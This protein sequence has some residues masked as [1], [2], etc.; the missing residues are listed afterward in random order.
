MRKKLWFILLAICTAG[1]VKAQPAGYYNTAHGKSGAELKIALYQIIKG[2]TEFSYRS[3]DEILDISD[4]DPTNPENVILV[5]TGRSDDKDNY[6]SGGN[7]INR[8]H[9]WAKSHGN[10]GTDKPAGSDVHNLKPADGSVNEDRSNLDFDNGGSQH[11]EATGCYYDGDSWEPRDAVKGDIARIIFYMAT[12][13]NGEN[14]EPA[15][16]VVDYVNTYPESEHGKLSTLL[17]WNRN[18]PPDDFERN[19]NEVIFKWQ[20]NRNPFIDH[21]EYVDLIWAA[22]VS[23]PIQIKNIHLSPEKPSPDNPVQIQAEIVDSDGSISSATI[24]WGTDYTNLDQS[25]PMNADGDTY[26]AQLPAQSEGAKV[27]FKI[28]ATDGVNTNSRRAYFEVLKQ[29]NGTLTPIKDVQG[30]TSSSPLTGNTVSVSGIVTA[31]FGENFFIQNE[32]G[33][34]NGIMIYDPGRNPAI[35]D[36]VVVTGTVKEY[37]N[38][39][40][41]GEISDFYHVSSHNALPEPVIVPTGDLTTGNSTAEQYEGVLVK[42]V[43]AECTSENPDDPNNYGQW[44]V[45]DGSGPCLIHNTAIYEHNQQEGEVYDITGVLNFDFD[46][47]K[48]EIRMPEDVNSGEDV[49]PPSIE[50]ITVSDGMHISI[51]F[52]EPL[53]A[54]TAQST[55]SYLFSD[56]IIIEQAQ[57]HPFEKNRVNLTVS[58][59]TVG[60]HTVTVSNIKDINDNA[61]SQTTET[62]TSEYFDNTAIAGVSRPNIEVFP[63]PVQHDAIFIRSGKSI[64]KVQAYSTTGKLMFSRHGNNSENMTLSLPDNLHGVFILKITSGN[65]IVLRKLIVR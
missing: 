47:Y 4:Q 31:N 11:N 52:S 51:V 39:T 64:S 62:F 41:V 55:D 34:W 1:I 48:I 6:G 60:E 59:L 16:E 49:I 18:D 42:V 58:G 32:K 23:N 36:S 21:P 53:D 3:T 19:R 30:Q 15:L 54:T 38:L 43:S 57:L 63:N 40:E 20:K 12:R 29:F 37:Y 8:E 28:E 45:N 56:N 65:H 10:F 13:Y 50:S 44:E 46:E 27:Y 14:G 61:M 35:G 26:S 17:E 2:H 22:A 5:Y 33:A 25:A 7:Y 9:V 24:F